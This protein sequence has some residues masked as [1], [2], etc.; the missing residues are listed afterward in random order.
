MAYLRT[1]SVYN[2]V[3]RGRKCRCF[4]LI[5]E[6]DGRALLDV[7]RFL[8]K[9]FGAG[10]AEATLI[11][12]A[13]HLRDFHEQLLVN[14]QAVGGVSISFLNG[15]RELIKARAT[16]QYAA[17]VLRTVLAYLD[18]LEQRG[19]ICGV[20][21]ETSGYA[22]VIGRTKSGGITHALSEGASSPKSNY[23]P[24]DRSIEAIKA[25]GP[26][27]AIQRERFELMIEWGH[28]KGL[29]AM[30]ICG[31]EIAQLPDEASIQKALE[32][33]QCLEMTLTVTKGGKSRNMDVHPLLLART[34]RWIEADR[35]L[36]IKRAAK[37]AKNAGRALDV[38]DHIFISEVTGKRMSP[39]SL[40]NAVRKAFKRA[41][42]DGVLT[43]AERVWTHGLRK[44]MINRELDSRPAKDRYSIENALRQETGHGSLDSLGR[45]VVDPK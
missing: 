11:T 32:E 10:G 13:A 44:R 40:S 9:Y 18:Y 39:K 45:Y 16:V 37:L 20:I 26:K 2:V 23:Y 33:N 17:Q 7:M 6:N 15:Y 41:V 29:R 27:G 35:P 25:R 21:G 12:Y 34:R 36:V 4:P 8:V 42:E 14:D 1:I 30:E 5:V 43:K 38:T 31:L 24:S 22:I 19:V 3:V 28:V